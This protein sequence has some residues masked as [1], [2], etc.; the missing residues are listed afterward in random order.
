METV[1]GV[2]KGQL[3]GS[4]VRAERLY[5]EIIAE[6]AKEEGLTEKRTETIIRSI[7]QTFME[8]VRKGETGISVMNLGSF[9]MK[10]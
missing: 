2:S 9:L 4:T 3:K 1:S 8:K 5:N 10:P 7:F 6:I